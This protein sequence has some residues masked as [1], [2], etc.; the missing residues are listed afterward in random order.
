MCRRARL[1]SR[2]S[3]SRRRCCIAVHPFGQRRR[4]GLLCGSY[5][6]W[7]PRSLLMHSLLS[8]LPTPS[9][10]ADLTNYTIGNIKGFNSFVPLSAYA[11]MLKKPQCVALL[12]LGAPSCLPHPLHTLTLPRLTLPRLTL[13]R[14]TL[15]RLTLPPDTRTILGSFTGSGRLSRKFT[16]SVKGAGHV[17]DAVFGVTCCSSSATS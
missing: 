17:N 13:P 7:C 16:R 6:P 10:T 4:E 9:S 5:L 15:P 14:L 11:T 1:L 3:F 2:R 12:T 8:H